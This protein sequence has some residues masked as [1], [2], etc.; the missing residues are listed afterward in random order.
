MDL[1]LDKREDK[2][3]AQFCSYISIPVRRA[4]REN[5]NGWIEQVLNCVGLSTLH[6]EFEHYF[7]PNSFNR[8]YKKS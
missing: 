8:G 5:G 6:D 4:I 1:V 7:E 3:L 2:A